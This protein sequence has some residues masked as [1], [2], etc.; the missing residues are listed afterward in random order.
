MQYNITKRFSRKIVK[1]YQSMEFMTELSKSV[2]VS[3][4]EQLIEEN[5]KLFEQAK[6]LTEADIELCLGGTNVAH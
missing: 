5:R 3:D 4:G 6:L 1:D 2:D